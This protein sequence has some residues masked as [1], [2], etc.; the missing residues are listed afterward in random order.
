MS[1]LVKAAILAGGFGTR[2]RPLTYTRP[3][4]LLPI[5]NVPMLRRII[6]RLPAEVDGV[7]LAVNY[8]ADH[9]RAYLAADPGPLPVD[10]V[11]EEEPLGTGGAVKNLEAAL[12]GEPFF[13]MNGDVVC[14]L[15]LGAMLAAHRARGAVGTIHVWPVEDPSRYGVVELADDGQI[16]S[17]TE[18]PPA[19]QAPS[20]LINAGTYV[21]EPDVLDLIPPG[22]AV[23]MERDVFPKVAGKGL[24][25]YR[26]GTFWVDA[27]KPLDYIEAHRLLLGAG[28]GQ[29]PSTPGGGGA[30][31]PPVLVADSARVEAGAR[32]GPN[33]AV[34]DGATIGAGARVSNSVLLPGADVGPDAVVEFAVLGEG[35]SVGRGARLAR[36]TVLADRA[37]VEEGRA[38]AA[39]EKVA[40]PDAPA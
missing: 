7:V 40:G 38:T 16:A 33:V 14:D 35:A 6:D 39:D 8:L 13:V 24:Y 22:R 1:S 2:M 30:F 28:G 20:D 31:E 36:G 32:V 11:E 37:V 19:G 3:K 5:L 26:G 34:G 12:G 15:D 27:G 23:S 17:F 21:L 4:P 25:A 29:A 18:K 9:V 10:V